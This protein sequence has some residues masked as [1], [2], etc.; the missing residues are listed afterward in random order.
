MA[1]LVDDILLAPFKLPAWISRKV[2]ESAYREMTDEA[3]I[4]NELLQLQMRLELGEVD[5]EEYERCEAKLLEDL[6]RARELKE[7]GPP[8]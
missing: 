2:G 1:F 4:R 3:S 8:F 6:G 5:E 7:E